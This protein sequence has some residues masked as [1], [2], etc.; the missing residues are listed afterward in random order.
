MAVGS[1]DGAILRKTAFLVAGPDEA[2]RAVASHWAVIF[3]ID[4]VGYV[5]V[6]GSTTELSVDGVGVGHGSGPFAVSV[7]PHE[8][9]TANRSQRVV[10]FPG[11]TVEADRLA[12]KKASTSI[13][14]PGWVPETGATTDEPGA[15]LLLYS[16]AALGAL[17]LAALGTGVSFG[18]SSE[19]L[20]RKIDTIGDDGE[21]TQLEIIDLNQR[22]ADTAR[23]ANIFL[24]VGAV[25][26]VAGA[27]LV[28]LDLWIL[29]SDATAHV[30]AQ[31]SGG[32]FS[33][34]V[35]LRW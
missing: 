29:D 33:A 19:S 2:D 9:A 17:G 4:G 1:Q 6:P 30:T 5:E 27:T 26:T 24:I 16:G 31:S 3:G 22:A 28:A 23:N 25:A 35:V 15:P 20:N 34:G 7:G 12:V 8:L 18:L 14:I 21:T 11:E 32:A 10:V 13:A